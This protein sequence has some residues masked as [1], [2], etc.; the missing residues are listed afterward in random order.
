MTEYDY[1]IIGGGMTADAAVHGIRSAGGKGSIGLIAG[2]PLTPYKRPPLSKGL[3][4]GESEDEIWLKNAREHATIH[5]SRNATGILKDRKEVVDDQGEKYAYRKLLLATGGSVRR[6][7]HDG[8]SVIYFRTFD[9]YTLLKERARRGS[10]A[11]V[12]GGGFIGSEIAAALAMSGVEVTMVFPEEGI[13]AR[14]YPRKLS[15]F[16]SE[17]YQQKGVRVI[18]GQGVESVAPAGEGALVKT[19]SGKEF[20]CDVVVAGI[21]IHPNSALAQSAGLEVGDGIVVNEFLETTDPDIYAAGDVANFMSA[22]LGRRIRL[23]HEDCATS[24]G[25]HAGGNM[26]GRSEPFRHL[27]FFYSDLFDLGYEA[28]GLLESRLEIVEEWKVEF[29]EG[30]IYYLENGRIRGILLWNRWGEL[31]NARALIG[32][33]LQKHL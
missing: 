22:P 13:G 31:E 8:Q 9:D 17:Y 16:L 27:P 28:V 23:E 5:A 1:L 15:G 29:R 25:E 6:L 21:G 3:W 32:K 4:K 14:V 33:E 18:A 11:V 26:A 10:K 24:M 12:I 30:T 7:P 19:S 2:E 20:R